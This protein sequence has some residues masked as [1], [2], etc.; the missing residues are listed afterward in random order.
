M[1]TNRAIAIPTDG[2]LRDRP[3]RRSVRRRHRRAGHR[4]SPAEDGADRAQR[5]PARHPDGARLGHQQTARP[6]VCRAR[7]TRPPPPPLQVDTPSPPPLQPARADP[8]PLQAEPPLQADA[9]LLQADWQAEIQQRHSASQQALKVQALLR[10]A[11]WQGRDANP[12]R[13]SEPELEAERQE[14]EEAEREEEELR[15]REARQYDVQ[16][17]RFLKIYAVLM[18]TKL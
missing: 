9:D 3:V 18:Q 2:A 1:T 17:G 12:Q 11:G 14:A 4:G 5:Q 6:P 13:V 8:P 16:R 15:C 10:E 7:R